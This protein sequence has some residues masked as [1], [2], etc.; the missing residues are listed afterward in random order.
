MTIKD[1]FNGTYEIE[2]NCNNC[3]QRSIVRIPKG[4][5]ISQFRT[6]KLIN[7]K[8]KC[9]FCGCNPIEIEKNLEGY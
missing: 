7:R 5:T 2:V 3:K 1:F 8:S 6:N 4:I 9:Q